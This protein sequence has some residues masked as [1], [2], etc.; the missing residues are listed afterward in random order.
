M[1]V[2]HFS[3]ENIGEISVYKRKGTRS[4][5]IRIVGS[6]VK[7]SIPK[8]MPYSYAVSFARQRQEWINK[9]RKSKP[10]LSDN[11]IIANTYMIITQKYD[12]TT[13]RCKISEY[14][15]MVKI[16]SNLAIHDTKVQQKIRS[17]CENA[18]LQKSQKTIPPRLEDLSKQYNFKF[19]SINFKK[20]K[21]RWGS[22]D[23][24]KNITINAHL[25][26]LPQKIID[27]ILIH[28]LTHTEHMNHSNMFWQRVEQCLPNYREIKKQLKHYSPEVLI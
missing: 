26:Q 15:I 18:L 1:S 17:A 22:C 11:V 23:R 7:I 9:H 19:N 14:S 12:G 16:P 2:K 21:S 10:L 27:Y 24:H 25:V 6:D 5:K 4:V 20:Q 13:I 8:W 3:L 28:E